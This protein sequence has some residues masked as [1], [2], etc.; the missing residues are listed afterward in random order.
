[1]APG[2]A[3]E[4]LVLTTWNV[5]YAGLGAD[6]DFI[7]EGGQR[8]RP[9]SRA[10]VERNLAGVVEH[11]AGIE[12][13]IVLMQE[14]AG[15]GLLTRNVD[16]LSGVR[17]ALPDHAM[18]FVAD[19]A[20]RVHPGSVALTHGPAVFTR[21]GVVSVE[22]VDLPDEPHAL[23]YLVK[24][25]YR[26]I[27]IDLD[28]GGRPW[29]VIGV[30]LAAYETSGVRARQLGALLELARRRHDEGRAVVIGGD[31]NMALR[32]FTTGE[33]PTKGGDSP[34]LDTSVLPVGWSVLA[35]AARGTVRAKDAPFDPHR[36][37]TSV[38]DGFIVSPNVAALEVVTSDLAFKFS[39]HHP[40]TVRLVRTD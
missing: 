11:L 2:P 21:R 1:M 20:S 10:V 28:V 5:G 30:H 25:D 17:G 19:V 22:V 31:F 3:V 37:F 27:S 23:A 13:D 9:L 38:I 33:V 26:A 12:S 16:V 35:D 18:T 34:P 39:D 36:T 24:R 40:V 32:E 29:T 15:P 8:L 7:A 4:P 6:A 14:L